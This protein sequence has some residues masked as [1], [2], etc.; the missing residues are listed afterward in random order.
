MVLHSYM[1]PSLIRKPK[2]GDWDISR[3]GPGLHLR[4]APPLPHPI[5]TH[6]VCF[7]L[8]SSSD[9]LPFSCTMTGTLLMAFVYFSSH[10][11]YD[12][13]VLCDLCWNSFKKTCEL[14]PKFPARKNEWKQRAE[15]ARKNN[16]FE[17]L[18]LGH[19]ER[20]AGEGKEGSERSSVMPS[21]TS[22]RPS[23]PTP[24]P[25]RGDSP[26]SASWECGQKGKL[27]YGQARQG[28]IT[29]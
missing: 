2:Q 3:L 26:R 22:T 23:A 5:H 6:T 4:R 9:E 13:E 16:S 25:D 10:K 14:L 18:V 15:T 20:I 21:A 19:T 24:I 28:I 29:R 8:T 7:S 11:G 1:I 17:S 27:N 12:E